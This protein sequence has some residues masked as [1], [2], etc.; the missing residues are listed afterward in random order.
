MSSQGARRDRK[1]ELREL[2]TAARSYVEQALM[3]ARGRTDALGLPGEGG[4]L[5]VAITPH[6]VEQLVVAIDALHLSP[7]PKRSRAH[8]ELGPLRAELLTGMRGLGE[9]R[10]DG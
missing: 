8:R 9:V 5:L 6:E 2:S 10:R 7:R 3:R 1:R 4:A